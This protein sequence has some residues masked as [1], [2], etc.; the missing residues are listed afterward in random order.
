ME[1]GK[2]RRRGWRAGA[3]RWREPRG[4]TSKVKV[5]GTAE[6]ALLKFPPDTAR[7]GRTR[8]PGSGVLGGPR[9]Q[10][11]ATKPFN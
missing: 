11:L 10:I 4:R 6:S 7:A 9:F 1:T 8:L 3:G 2:R 5:A